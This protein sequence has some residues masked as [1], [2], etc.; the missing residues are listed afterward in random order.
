M[1]A[2]SADEPSAGRRAP[3]APPF[4]ALTLTWLKLGV[5]L[6]LG[7]ALALRLPAYTT[8][9]TYFWRQDLGV[10]LAFLALAIAFGMASPAW[11]ARFAA[12]LDWSGRGWALALAAL[13]LV[14]GV[15]G[16]GLV[17][18]NYTLSLD[19]FLANFD[20]KIF[21]SGR[22]MAP[23]PPAWRGY[24]PALAPI[25]M[26]P[27]A[28]NVDW[29][30]GY[31]PINAAVRALASKIGAEDVVNPALS[32][33]AIVATFAIGRRL[34]PEQPRIGAIAAILLGASAQLVVTA[35]TAYAMPMHL[36]LNLAW[37][38][39]FLRGGRLGH[40]GAIAVGFFATGIHQL[41]FHPLFVAPFVLQLWLDRRWALAG[42]YTAAYGMI[43]GFWVEY[44]PLEMHLAGVTAPAASQLGGG[45]SLIKR[46]AKLLGDVSVFNV[47]PM[48]ECLFRFITWQHPLLA[49]VAFGGLLAAERQKGH[50]RALA[51]GVV[52]TLLAMLVLV[53]TQS[54]GWGY[55]YLHGLLGST[56]L[57]AA[58]TWERM[59]AALDAHRRA[60][61]NGAMV[62]ATV[63]ALVVFLPLR[64][65]Q[66]W[67]Y[68]HPYAMANAEI[69][70]AKTQVVIVD[71]QGPI[72]FDMG[73]LVRND[74]FLA[75]PKVLEISSLSDDTVADLCAHYSVSVFDGA[76]A[77]ALGIDVVG[78]PADPNFVAI[79][80][81]MADAHCGVRITHR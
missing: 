50:L 21:A 8:E 9:T 26:L 56:A 27:V 25:Y 31:L 11:L 35:M 48:G 70:G 74:P 69:Q 60:A 55:R 3:L 2:T 51:F 58:W 6:G 34:F 10:Y 80:K 77:K 52:L 15:V 23:L 63:L 46:L 78:V 41:L 71:D 42:A 32:A 39:L 64:G 20:A 16:V 81:Q 4:G 5:V 66:S 36:A 59:T 67:T 22:L 57:I 14:A 1:T 49:P 29:A 75:G 76:E 47:A 44:W 53:P 17:F 13:C 62:L 43:C 61:A 37:L 33:F 18:D 30:S 72:G 68:C 7:A 40:L 12:P 73:T 38:W 79:R 28:G 65:W 19:E 45:A 24:E 54:N